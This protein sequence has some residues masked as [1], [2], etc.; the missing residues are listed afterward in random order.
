MPDL[1]DDFPVIC[2]SE[3]DVAKLLPEREKIFI[4]KSTIDFANVQSCFG[5]ALHMRQPTILDVSDRLHT[6]SLISNLQYM[7]EHPDIGDNHNAPVYLHCYSRISDIIKDLAL[8]GG[9]PNYA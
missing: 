7:L 4:S 6:D 5:V 2:G 3:A 9:T 8:K 1:T